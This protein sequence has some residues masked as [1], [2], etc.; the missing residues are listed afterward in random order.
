LEKG[1]EAWGEKAAAEKAPLDR[2]E[3][4]VALCEA[5]V[6]LVALDDWVSSEARRACAEGPG[7]A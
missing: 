7:Y 2:L 3:S 5:V 1:Q 4:A 6:A